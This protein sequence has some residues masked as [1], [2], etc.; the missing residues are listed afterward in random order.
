MKIQA[1]IYDGSGATVAE[2]TRP[3]V[4]LLALP[5]ITRAAGQALHLQIGA[6]VVPASLPSLP[7]GCSREWFTPL[8]SEVIVCRP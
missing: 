2:F 8:N 1:W 4:A 7:R 5:A 6:S 3:V